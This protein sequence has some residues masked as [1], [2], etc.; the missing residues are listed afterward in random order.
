MEEF[1]PLTE[2]DD[3]IVKEYL[4]RHYIECTYIV[5][6]FEKYGFYKDN[7]NKKS[8]KYYGYFIDN[9]L[10]GIFVFYNIGVASCHYEEKGILNKLVLL[11]TI[12]KHKPVHIVGPKKYIAPIIQTFDK[13][14]RWDNL[15]ICHFM[16]LDIDNFIEDTNSEHQIVNAVDYD[17]KCSVDFLIKM[18]S[19]FRSKTKTINDLKNYI[20]DKDNHIEYIYISVENKTVA[21]GLI[22]TASKCIELI[23]GV[24]TLSEYRNNGYAK[25]IVSELCNRVKKKNK[26]PGLIVHKSNESAIHL[27]KRLGFRSTYEYVTIDIIM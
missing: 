7:Q 12:K 13:V 3:A 8:G 16:L 17:F 19:D 9:T 2:A 15:N 4:D 6:S 22:K 18:E 24:Y 23:E 27:Y 14:F 10:K 5:D 11:H 1:R 20:Y 25:T 26:Q 21:Q